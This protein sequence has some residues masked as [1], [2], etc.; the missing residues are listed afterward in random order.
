M[1]Q[2][3]NNKKDWA[4][5]FLSPKEIAHSQAKIQ[6]FGENHDF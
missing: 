6:F 2:N 3:E 1:K 5:L 4:V